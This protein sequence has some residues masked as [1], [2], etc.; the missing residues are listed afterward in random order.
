MPVAGNFTEEDAN[1]FSQDNSLEYP[2]QRDEVQSIK[3][4]AGDRNIP[5][6]NQIVL[7]KTLAINKINNAKYMFNYIFINFVFN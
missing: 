2:L 3:N 4:K 5:Q 1:G 7:T 6:G